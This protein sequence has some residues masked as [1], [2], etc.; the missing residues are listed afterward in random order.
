LVLLGEAGDVLPGALAKALDELQVAC[1]WL[2]AS[3]VLTQVQLRAFDA[4]AGG[5]G[6]VR[7]IEGPV[8]ALSIEGSVGL[9]RGEVTVGLRA[10]LARET[11][12]GMETLAGEIVAARVVALEA[13][14]TA[15]DD[16][17]LGRA[18][19]PAAN[20]WML[21]E[22]YGAKPNAPKG[23]ERAPQP[24]ERAAPAEEPAPMPAPKPVAP[25]STWQEAISASADAEL[26]RGGTRG[27]GGAV[28]PPRPV[29]AEADH[30]GPVPEAGDAVEHFAFGRAEVIKSDGE[31]LHLRA[32]KDGRIREIALEMLRVTPLESPG[33][34]RRFRL[35]RKQ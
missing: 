8:Q 12:R 18:T 19:D 2:R 10:V 3:G 13:A 23:P 32:E 16:L 15:F 25:T 1:G 11:D 6:A 7:R 9:A 14:V 30:E 21:A 24:Q 26:L 29:R 17:A 33:P 4:S 5:P 27:T 28:V 34:N 35:D 20:V 31:R 22:A